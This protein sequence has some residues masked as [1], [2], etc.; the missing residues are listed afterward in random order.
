MFKGDPYLDF[1]TAG[2]CI[3]LTVNTPCKGFSEECRY[4]SNGIQKS[5]L[6]G[7]AVDLPQARV[8][9]GVMTTLSPP[10]LGKPSFM[11]TAIAATHICPATLLAKSGWL[12]PVGR[13]TYSSKQE[14][15]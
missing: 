11:V 5:Q 6:Y 8:Q 3:V 13:R 4:V 15:G 9:L 14:C 2:I 10:S 1:S 12:P 7:T